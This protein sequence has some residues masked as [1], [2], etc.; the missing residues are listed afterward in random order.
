MP[1]ILTITLTTIIPIVIIASLGALL[2]WVWPLEMRTISRIAIYIAGPALAFHGMAN[3]A[4]EADELGNLFLFT[5]L[6]TGTI[7]LITW[8]AT[9][10]MGLDRVTASAFVLS[11]S[12]LNAVNYGIP[13]NEFAFGEIGGQLAIVVGVL[14]GF[15]T[16]TIGVFFAS[17]GKASLKQALINIL[18]V[19]MAYAALLGLSLNLANLPIP[20]LLAQITG[21]LNG[22][23]VPLMLLILGIQIYRSPLQGQWPVIIG[24]SAIRLVGGAIIGFF[25]AYLLGLEGE[26][27]QVAIVEA[28]MP[29][30]V[31]AVLLATE[32][33][34]D[35][36]LVSSTV[37]VS[38]L[39]SLLTLPLVI[40][41]VS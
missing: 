39:L 8:L 6:S 12:L 36:R 17:W 26:I 22:A 40:F 23:A 33:E 2:D 13:L 32:F 10:L 20:E 28:A 37:L 7:T 27:R 16:Y 41:L 1:Q 35:A 21:V 3:A 29:T 25:F 24:A 9:Y 38:T 5:I 15:Y 30:A 18:K 4:V 11:T 19:P 14:G 34:S 31:T